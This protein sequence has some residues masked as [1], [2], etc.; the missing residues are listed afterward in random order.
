MFFKSRL[1][2]FAIFLSSYTNSLLCHLICSSITCDEDHLVNRNKG[3]LGLA[4]GAQVTDKTNLCAEGSR[5]VGAGMGDGLGVGL[6][7][8]NF[9][10]FLCTFV[11]C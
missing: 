3:E 7:M 2:D 4:V 9:F 10:A 11:L 1:K 6:L 5:A 8:R